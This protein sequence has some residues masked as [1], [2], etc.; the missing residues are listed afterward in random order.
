MLFLR[1]IWVAEPCGCPVP[2]LLEDISGPERTALCW[3]LAA[4]A[5][6]Q[7]VFALA[8]V[9]GIGPPKVRTFEQNQPFH[10]C[11]DV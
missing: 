2:I 8:D 3:R 10:Q 9:I 4:A 11:D 1:G 6:S 7:S 5:Y